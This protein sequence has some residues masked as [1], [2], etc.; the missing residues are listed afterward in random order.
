[1]TRPSPGCRRRW[2]RSVERPGRRR[3]AI[4]ADTR[5]LDGDAQAAA[6][7]SVSLVRIDVLLDP[8][9]VRGR[10][11]G[12]PRPRLRRANA[13]AFG[14]HNGADG[15]D[16]GA[17]R[18]RRFCG[19]KVRDAL[20]AAL[21]TPLRS[22]SVFT[23]LS[24]AIIWRRRLMQRRNSVSISGEKPTSSSL[25]TPPRLSTTRM[26]TFTV[27]GRQGGDAQLDGFPAD[28]DRD[29]SVLGHAALRNIKARQDLDAAD[30]RR[31][32]SNRR[33]QRLGGQLAVDAVAEP[34]MSWRANC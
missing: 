2:T 21:M 17:A 27:S 30:H 31:Q 14:C 25:R 13:Q 15:R 8:S 9:P 16:A 11:R 3:S 33:P 23:P 29:V 7:A 20:L 32:K 28:R 24:C 12:C 1:M 5:A 19:L 34:A 4:V 6:T 26:M 22:G 10:A 18:Q